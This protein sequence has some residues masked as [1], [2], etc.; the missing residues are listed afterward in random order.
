MTSIVMDIGLLEVFPCLGDVCPE[1]WAEAKPE[2]RTFSAKSRIFNREEARSYGMFL[3]KGST[4]ISQIGKD[5]SERVVNKLNPGEICALLVLSG[6]SGRDYPA[7]I[8]AETEVEALFVSKISFL[9]WVQEYESIRKTVFGNLLEGIMNMG[10]QL[11][12]RQTKPLEMRLAEAL[13]SSTSEQR[14]MLRMTHYELASEIG[15]AR[16]VVSRTL[17]RF[18][19]QGWVEIGRGWVKITCRTKLE[20]L[21]VTR[22]QKR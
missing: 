8:E 12:A 11:Q 18:R 15:T 10:E 16:E 9:H 17:Q 13:L 2:I 21:S 6:L 3:L 22:S 5:G 19:R 14:P 4:R 1:D 7:V 20:E